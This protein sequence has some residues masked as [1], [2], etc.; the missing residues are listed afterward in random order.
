[1]VSY[2]VVLLAEIKKK[3]EPQEL[4]CQDHTAANRREGF[5]SR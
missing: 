5:E 4:V 3:T 2:I 1:M